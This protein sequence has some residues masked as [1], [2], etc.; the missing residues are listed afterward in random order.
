MAILNVYAIHNCM[1][2]TNVIIVKYNDF[3]VHCIPIGWLLNKHAF[4]LNKPVSFSKTD[5]ANK[6]NISF[7]NNRQL[8]GFS[9]SQD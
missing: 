9:L 1:C 2:Y 3:Y 7:Y 5:F 6:R 4:L 8:Y